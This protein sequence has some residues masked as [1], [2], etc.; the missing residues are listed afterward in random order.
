ME[1]MG[2]KK[3]G[4]RAETPLQAEAC[5]AFFKREFPNESV[6]KK[7]LAMERKYPDDYLKGL[8][9]WAK[10][11]GFRPF[12]SAVENPDN[13]QDWLKKNT[14]PP[15]GPAIAGGWSSMSDIVFVEDTEE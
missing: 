5:A 2:Q 1:G 7:F 6:K 11:K 14:T 15:G 8:I 10:G 9:E 3:E 12:V 13:Y 4:L